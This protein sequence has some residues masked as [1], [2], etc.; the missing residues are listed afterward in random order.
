[1]AK[2]LSPAQKQVLRTIF[3][4]QRNAVEATLLHTEEL[5]HLESSEVFLG[6]SDQR[7]YDE[8]GMHLERGDKKYVKNFAGK[9][10]LK[11]GHLDKQE[12]SKMNLRNRDCEIVNSVDWLTIV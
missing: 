7:N 3:G 12:H 11:S 1:M 5:C 9:N 10:L 8:P 6:L 4:P 2:T